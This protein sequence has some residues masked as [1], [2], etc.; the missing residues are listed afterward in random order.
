M[1]VIGKAALPPMLDQI[2]AWLNSIATRI[3]LYQNDYTPTPDSGTGSF[4]APTF[5]G[6][7]GFLPVGAWSVSTLN[8]NGEAVI[9]AAVQVW[10]QTGPTPANTI[11]GYYL[12]SAADD[13][14]W[15]ERN[16]AGGVLMNAAGLS[17]TVYPQFRFRN[18]TQALLAL[19]SPQGLSTP[20]GGAVLLGGP[21]E[22][23]AEAAPPAPAAPPA[24]PRGAPPAER[25]GTTRA[26]PPARP[27]PGRQ[28]PPGKPQR[29]R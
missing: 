29:G 3:R 16:P 8:A 12:T 9:T 13:Y 14:L 4:V 18:D 17:Y 19:E 5:P 25:P 22:L 26:A 24:A 10:T 28:V 23:H 1:I 20:D 6:Y 15:G 21:H 27:D 11:Y 7:G 2:R